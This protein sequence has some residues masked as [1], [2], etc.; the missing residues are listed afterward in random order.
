[1]KH[2]QPSQTLGT[3]QGLRGLL[4]S[5]GVGSRTLWER[6]T[7]SMCILRE[8]HDKGCACSY[9]KE[10][11]VGLI[12]PENKGRNSWRAIRWKWRG[13]LHVLRWT[14]PDWWP[15]TKP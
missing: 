14:L 9:C 10:G 13:A 15:T 5:D 3:T 12:L 4:N 6:H 11:K 8:V 1:M 2:T 7:P